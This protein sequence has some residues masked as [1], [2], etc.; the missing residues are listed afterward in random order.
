MFLFLNPFKHWH[1]LFSI[2]NLYELREE[3]VNLLLDSKAPFIKEQIGMRE[4]PE[5]PGNYYL[6]K[7]L[8]DSLNF[9]VDSSARRLTGFFAAYNADWNYE[10]FGPVT[11]PD[12]QGFVLG[13]NRDNSLDSRM[14][15]FIDLNNIR[16]V[17]LN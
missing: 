13:D 10:N 12:G 16:Q 9:K 5:G 14:F 4:Q 11:V 15:G 7:Y 3:E 2:Y 17:V 8:G 6:P 1:E